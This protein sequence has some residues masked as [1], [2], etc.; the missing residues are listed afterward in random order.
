MF[1]PEANSLM[2]D[3]C[4]LNCIGKSNFFA[5]ALGGYETRLSKDDF[6]RVK[7][8]VENDILLAAKIVRFREPELSAADVYRKASRNE[9][10][11]DE[12]RAAF[13]EL[14]KIS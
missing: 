1:R 13:L 3:E 9:G 8:I 6:E 11:S 12:S 5:G 4:L 2:S 10:L 14:A 7:D